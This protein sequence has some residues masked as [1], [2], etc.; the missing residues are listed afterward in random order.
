[1][2]LSVTLKTAGSATLTA[3][4]T[5]H[6]ALQ[7]STTPSL[8]VLA[9]A[10]SKLQILAPGETAAPGSP[11]GKTGTP[12]AQTA[13]NACSVTVNAVDANWNVVTNVSD[14]IG[15]T[16]SDSNAALPAG[17]ALVN[18]TKA[19]SVTFKTAGN[20]SLTASNLTDNSKT[21]SVSPAITVN[22]GAF[23]KLQLLT[24]GETAAPGTATGKSG[25]PSPQPGGAAFNVTVNAVDANWNLMNTN[26][27]VAITSSDV[28]ASLPANAALVNGTKSLS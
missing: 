23:A 3:S 9:A 18:G 13:G 10:F 2:T 24:P 5:T 21:A 6:P 28:N 27:T 15:V 25:S 12:S 20:S 26:D 19:L 16:S 17:T 4:D 14:T 8:Q 11:R 22:P 7:N 1:K